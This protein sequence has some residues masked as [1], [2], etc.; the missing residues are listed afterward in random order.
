MR[1]TRWCAAEEWGGAGRW[2][3]SP[4]RRQ[5]AK[6]EIITT[7]PS[8]AQPRSAHSGGGAWREGRW[9]ALVVT[10]PRGETLTAAAPC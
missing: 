6:A 10:V 4:Q 3:K 9:V 5:P 8:P 2:L 7:C 1:G